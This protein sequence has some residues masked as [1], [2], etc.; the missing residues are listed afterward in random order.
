MDR[1]QINRVQQSLD[2]KRAQHRVEMVA[3]VA[4]M[5]TIG[6]SLADDSPGLDIHYP[7]DESVVKSGTSITL[8][9]R[10]LGGFAPDRLSVVTPV[11]EVKIVPQQGYPRH[12]RSYLIE[13]NVPEQTTGYVVLSVIGVESASGR[14]FSEAITLKVEKPGPLIDLEIRNDRIHLHGAEASEKLKVWGL[15]IDG[16]EKDLS[17]SA[18]GTT[19]VSTQ[20]IF[21]TVDSEGI[22]RAGKRDGRSTVVATNGKE[23][24]FVNVVVDGVNGTPIFE[25]SWDPKVRVNERLEF[26]VT[27][28]DPESKVPSLHAEILPAGATF[29]DNGDGTGTVRWTPGDQST[30]FHDVKIVATDADDPEVLGAAWFVIEVIP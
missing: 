25:T 5:F 23:S 21:A 26:L 14:S 16:S 20:P 22:V 13:Y 28:T 3:I 2:R 17:G 4:T 11:G 19:Y 10:P 24:M 27:V 18:T 12:R 15:Y 9:V 30:K 1:E 8:N 29:V 7:P 6:Q